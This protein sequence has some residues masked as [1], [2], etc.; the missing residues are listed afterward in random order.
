MIK[1]SDLF[2]VEYGNSFEL[3]RL[4]ETENGINFISRTAK[5][6]GVS[7]KVERIESVC[8]FPAGL[9]T[10]S[11]GGT[12]L[13]A[14]LQPTPFYTGYHIYIL[15]PKIELTDT[16]KLFYCSCI[17]AN[18]YRY[19]YG[20]QANKTLKEIHIPSLE[21]LPKWTEQLDLNLDCVKLSAKTGQLAPLNQLKWKL[22]PLSE[23][24]T[25]SKGKRLTKADMNT[26]LTP[27]IGATEFN[28]GI[29]NYIDQQPIHLGNTITI[30]YNGNSVAE[31]F[32][33][34]EPFWATDDVN[35]LY[36]KFELNVYI[37]MFLITLFRQ[38][39]YRFNY[40]RKWNLIR[41]NK[42][43]INL[44]VNENGQPDFKFMEDYIKSLPYSS[45]LTN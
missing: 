16:Q 17:R 1:I 43:L 23:L 8:P 29:T 32:Y 14:F 35:V 13:E 6:N 40:G 31:A 36:P 20:R 21:D 15:S 44:P 2:D 18:K 39:K 27:F 11:L 19:N 25:I 26:G 3:N 45:H 7:A 12:V 34:P 41:M 33:Q 9:I 30:P 4:T 28:N 42:S 37:A 24:F 10:V 38:E 5:N 22:F